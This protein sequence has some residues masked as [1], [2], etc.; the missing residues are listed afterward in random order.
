MSDFGILPLATNIA[1][2]GRHQSCRRAHLEHAAASLPKRMQGALLVAMVSL[3][4]VGMAA[5]RSPL[6]LC[7]R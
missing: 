7:I 5:P 2:S 1:L 4:Q 3:I 6:P